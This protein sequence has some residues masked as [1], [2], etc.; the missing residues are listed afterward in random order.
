LPN[1]TDEKPTAVRDQTESPPEYQAIVTD[2]PMTNYSSSHFYPQAQP[3]PLNNGGQQNVTV[4]MTQVSYWLLYYWTFNHESR[5]SRHKNSS[6]IYSNFC[7][8]F[9]AL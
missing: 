6:T 8:L 9:F 7:S 1:V 3:R 5:T 2:V 4:V